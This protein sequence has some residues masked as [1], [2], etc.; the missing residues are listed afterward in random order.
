MR[1]GEARQH[2]AVIAAGRVPGDALGLQHRD[3]PAAPRDLARDGQAGE[4]A[5]DHAD[6]DVEIEGERARARAPAPWSRCTSS[7]RSPPARTRSRFLPC[8]FRGARQ[9]PQ[10]MLNCR[11]PEKSMLLPMRLMLLRHAKSEKAEPGMRDHERT[12]NARGRSET[13]MIG[14]YMA[15]HGLIPDR[16]IVST[17]RRTR[18]TWERLAP[19]FS[20]R[21]AGHLRGAPLRQRPETHPRHHQGD[22]ARRRRRCWSSAT[23]PACTTP[24]GC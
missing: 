20:T 22:R 6:I 2:E 19:A 13:P 12:L 10:D 5:A 18:E 4:A 8:R 23:I 3:R 7:A 11:T 9:P 1:L 17:A 21:S 16:V 15:R 24:R 14:A